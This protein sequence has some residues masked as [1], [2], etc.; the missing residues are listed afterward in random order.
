MYSVKPVSLFADYRFPM[1]LS[2]VDIHEVDWHTYVTTCG[3]EREKKRPA[4][5]GGGESGT[6]IAS[7]TQHSPQASVLTITDQE[8]TKTG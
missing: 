5:P 7:S 8:D 6:R 2:E 3:L 4:Y 1:V